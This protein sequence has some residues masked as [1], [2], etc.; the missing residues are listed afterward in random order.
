MVFYFGFQI[1][2]YRGV[3]AAPNDCFAALFQKRAPAR[4]E[5][6]KIG[7]FFLQSFFAFDFAKQMTDVSQARKNVPLMAKEKALMEFWYL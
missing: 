7:I 6:K 4:R 3:I 5:R 2:I 1:L